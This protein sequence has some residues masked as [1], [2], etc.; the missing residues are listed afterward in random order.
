[1]ATYQF[2]PAP[3]PESPPRL[4]LLFWG[5][6]DCLP[7]HA[8]GPGTRDIYKI[9]FVHKGKGIV[10]R[11]AN[12]FELAAGQAFLI[13]PHVVYYYEAD[14]DDPWT[15][16]WIGFQGT[17]VPGLLDRT[18][19]SDLQPVFVMDNKIMPVLYDQLTAADSASPAFDLRLMSVFYEFLAALLESSGTEGAL[20]TLSGRQEE[21]VQQTLEFLH[22]HYSE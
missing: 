17:D 12:T 6:E 16:S 11:G 22:S 5:K 20:S 8:A 4:H 9:H 13:Y 3:P 18:Q 14:A 10:R 2:N 7:G 15:Y 19:L 21:Y 1:M